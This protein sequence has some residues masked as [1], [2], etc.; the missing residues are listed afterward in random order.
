MNCLGCNSETIKF[1]DLGKTPLANNYLP[2][3]KMNAGIHPLNVCFCPKCYLIQLG[4]KIDP[5]ELY[6]DYAYFSSYS[7]EFLQ[8]AKELAEE[9]IY[10]GADSSTSVLEIASND[11]YLLQYLQPYT[12][13][14]GVEPATNI[15]K[16]ANEKNIPTK[17]VFFN[18]D[19]AELLVQQVKKFDFIIGN[20]V[21]AH[22]PDIN[23]FIKGVHICLSAD[24][25]AMFEFPYAPVMLNRIEFDTIYHEHVFY[26]TVIA[27]NKLFGRHNLE[28]Y[29]IRFFPIHGG[30]IRIYVQHKS[31]GFVRSMVSLYEMQERLNGLDS[32]DSYN[33]FSEDVKDLKIKLNAMLWDLKGRGAKIAAYGAAAKGNTLLNYCGIT[34]ELIDFTVDR[35]PHKQNKF[36]PGSLIPIFSPEK[37]LEKKPDYTLMLT[38]NFKEEIMQQQK[39]Y[40]A[41]GGKFII[42]V[43]SPRIVK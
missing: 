25:T 36:L 41:Q 10:L 4:D 12:Q 20:N 9:I 42:P 15:A 34:T 3:N 1:L 8:H 26:Y 7:G 27:L 35:S 18:S 31:C 2:D 24:G 29:D 6:S 21:L 32:I 33:I 37:L 23:D 39:E 22:V 17:N 19:V 40:L 5:V 16:E 30:S 14:L 11:G 38:W 28:I 13:V 43:P